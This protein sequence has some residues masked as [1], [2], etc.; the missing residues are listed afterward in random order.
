MRLQRHVRGKQAPH[1]GTMP[2]VSWAPG[3]HPQVCLRGSWEVHLYPKQLPDWLV[4]ATSSLFERGDVLAP[5]H[6]LWA[7]TSGPAPKEVGARISRWGHTCTHSAAEKGAAEK[8]AGAL[9]PAQAVSPAQT[10]PPRQHRHPLQFLV[11]LQL[12]LHLAQPIL[13]AAM[14][15]SHLSAKNSISSALNDPVLTARGL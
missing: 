4:R 12:G 2:S 7:T 5:A 14:T 9:A 3:W 8:G 6:H 15:L 13:H 11:L 1:L 10:P